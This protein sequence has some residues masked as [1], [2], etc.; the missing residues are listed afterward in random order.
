MTDG[1]DIFYRRWKTVGE[2]QRA[3]VCI[4]GLPGQSEQFALIG[5]DFAAQGTEVYAI[6]L[7]G[8][9]SSV[10]EGLARG[11]TKDVKRHLQ[12]LDEVVGE[13]R[14]NHPGKHVFML[15][16]S[17]GCNYALWFVASHRD[18][19]EGLILVAPAIKRTSKIPAMDLL[20]FLLALVLAPKKTYDLRRVIADDVKKSN[21]FKV[22]FDDPMIPTRV[23]V[24]YLGG[25]RPLL[26]KVL[27]NASRTEEPTLIIQGDADKWVQPSGATQ[28][29]E[30][31]PA[32]DK[33]LRSF[34]GA[35]HFF[36]DLLLPDLASQSDS[37]K[38]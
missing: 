4:H 5:R 18:T 16:H 38:R 1:F 37:E 7:R 19:L 32:K 12:D 31:L 24:R 11:D 33:S 27:S 28:L 23:S 13:I 3:V 35:D 22:I 21:E 34:P 8:F 9:G 17:V 36:F 25:T 14:K 26:D 30:T 10:E 20:P 2:A 6:D 29:L 15:G